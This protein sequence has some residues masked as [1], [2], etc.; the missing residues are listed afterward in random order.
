MSIIKIETGIK[1]LNYQIEKTFYQCYS[2]RRTDYNYDVYSCSKD[3]RQYIRGAGNL[4]K[5]MKIIDE[6]KLNKANH[7]TT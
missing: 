2:G 4:T 6:D 3:G 1:G 7:P 5:A